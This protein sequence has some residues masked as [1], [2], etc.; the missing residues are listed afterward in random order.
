MNVHLESFLFKLSR[1]KKW[2]NRKI[3]FKFAMNIH[4]FFLPEFQIG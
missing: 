1:K 3:I 4:K 2:I